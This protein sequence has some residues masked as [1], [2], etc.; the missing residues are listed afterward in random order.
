MNDELVISVYGSHNAAVAM[1]YK[2]VYRVIEFERWMNI[3]NVGLLHY[4]PLQDPKTYLDQ[5]INYLLST[6]DKTEIDVYLTNYADVTGGPNI[7]TVAPTARFHKYIKFDHHE[8]HASA[9][10]Y[11]SPF[12]DALTFTC[13]SGGDTSYFN[14]YRT[15]R[16]NGVE[17]LDK[18]YQDLGFGYMILADHMEDIRREGLGM[19]SIVYAG[20][21]MGLCSYGN[22]REEWLPAFHQFY[23]FF[24]YRGSSLLGGVKARQTGVPWLMDQLGVKDFGPDVRFSGQFAYDLA[25]TTQHVF[26]EQFYKFTQPWLDKYPDLPV[27]MSGGCG[28]NVILNSR[29][30]NERNGKV[31]APPDP[32]DCGIAAGGML[33]YVNP[34]EP[35]DLT[36]SGVPIMDAGDAAQLVQENNFTVIDEVTIP[37][38]AKFIKKGK[39]VGL[40]NG[41]SE[42]GPRSLGNRS[43]IC[44]PVGN[45][46]EV[47]NDKV[48]HREWYR[49][50]APVVRLEDVQKYFIF[51]E[52]TESRHMTFVSEIKDEWKESI[53]AVVHEDG[54][55]RLQTVTR[56]QNEFLYDLLTEFDAIS[57][58]GVLLNTSFNVNGKPILSRLSD[59]FDILANTELDAV[60][61]QGR[62]IFR[63]VV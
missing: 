11:Q 16:E 27:C 51:P 49:P 45:M 4:Y 21:L 48:K 35:A 14:V 62:L 29:L 59:A 9:A 46:K 58:H 55:G 32:N 37:D 38:L 42:H 63:T 43:I 31:F 17:L 6:T 7:K 24:N 41:N 47:L 50:F 25:A 18:F 28:L 40:I 22:V 23:E 8:A 61:Y 20:K 12:D 1:H 54:T 56:E 26:E 60:Y 19:G 39:I 57:D 36:Y 53:P 34:S 44:D 30:L 13:D 5:V 3:K 2:G 15:S 10:F 33:Q 52:N